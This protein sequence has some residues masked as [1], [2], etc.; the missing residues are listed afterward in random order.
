SV[1]AAHYDWEKLILQSGYHF[2]YFDG[3][4]R[5]YIAHEHLELVEAFNCPPNVFDGFKLAAQQFAEDSLAQVKQAGADMEARISLAAVQ[6]EEAEARAVRAEARVA[7]IET[8][9]MEAAAHV[10]EA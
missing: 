10:S 3:L 6:I 9:L 1:E 5:F 8:Y 7:E 2:V 4:N